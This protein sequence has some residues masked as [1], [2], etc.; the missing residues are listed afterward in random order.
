MNAAS[1]FAR[2]FQRWGIEIPA[3]DIAAARAGR[4]Q[5]RGWNIAYVFGGSE[6]EEIMEFYAM[7][8]MTDNRH[9]RLWKGGRDESLEAVAD[10]FVSNPNVPGDAERGEQ[11][12]FANNARIRQ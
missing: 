4:I 2:T 7:H 5:S 3:E 10:G 12:Y 9:L 1:R 6:S 11:R 8:P